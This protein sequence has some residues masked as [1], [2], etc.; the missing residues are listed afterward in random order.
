M[1]ASPHHIPE[2]GEA[3]KRVLDEHGLSLRGQKIRTGIDHMTMKDM[4]DGLRPRLEKVEQ[5]ARAFGLDVNEWRELA[6]YPRVEEGDP[7]RLAAQLIKVLGGASSEE[8]EDFGDIRASD[9]AGNPDDL[10]VLRAVERLLRNRREGG[11]G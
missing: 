2:F 4:C 11:E 10:K 1:P 7:D 9:G 5:F 6:G 3:V 8:D